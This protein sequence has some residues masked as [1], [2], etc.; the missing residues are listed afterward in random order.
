[1]PRQTTMIS[2]LDPK[3]VPPIIG[4]SV[5]A[6][7]CTLLVISSITT[8]AIRSRYRYIPRKD[9]PLDFWGWISLF[10]FLALLLWGLLIF[11]VTRDATPPIRSNTPTS[12]VNTGG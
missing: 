10:A 12:P 6:I 9:Y 1:M 2:S 8:G 3:M 11:A 7:F 5:T 4:I